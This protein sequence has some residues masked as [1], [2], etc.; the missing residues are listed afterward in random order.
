MSGHS[1]LLIAERESVHLPKTCLLLACSVPT[2]LRGMFCCSPS[3]KII[4]CST[5]QFYYVLFDCH[6]LLGNIEIA[7]S[8]SIN[9]LSLRNPEKPNKQAVARRKSARV[10]DLSES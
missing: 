1:W 3:I 9:S 5:D 8:Q 7:G 4:A 6:H 10:P 2:W